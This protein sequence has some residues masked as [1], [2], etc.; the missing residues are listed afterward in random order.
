MLLIAACPT[1][2]TSS[3][4]SRVYGADEAGTRDV[5]VRTISV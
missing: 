5:R 4:Y 1:W 2:R 3:M